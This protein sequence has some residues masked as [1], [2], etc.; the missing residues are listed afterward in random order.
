M[1]SP[2]PGSPG[3]IEH[4]QF[5]RR[6]DFARFGELGLTASVQPAHALDDRDAAE[7]NWS[8]AHRPGLP[9]A[10]PARGRRDAGTRLRCAG[11]C[12]GSVGCDVGRDHPGAVDGRGPWHPEQGL[13]RR[14]ALMA[15]TRGRGLIRVGDPA[16][17]AVLD[18]D[19]LSVPD[20]VFAGMPVAATLVAGR[21]TFRDAGV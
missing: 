12:A 14:E 18:A 9:A 10:V 4:A 11:G 3:R 15:S 8:R 5:V 1:R 21:F 13:T 6:E 16:D 19:P 17:I 7:A 2:R 20:E